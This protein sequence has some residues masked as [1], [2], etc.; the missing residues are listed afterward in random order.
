MS[1]AMS[2]T[3]PSTES[4]MLK[5]NNYVEIIEEIGNK[6]ILSIGVI[7][8]TKNIHL[9]RFSYSLAG[10]DSD[11]ENMGLFKKNIY[12]SLIL[13]YGWDSISKDETIP[14][15]VRY[16]KVLEENYHNH[17]TI[18]DQLHPVIK[19]FVRPLPSRL[20]RKREDEEYR[21]SYYLKRDDMHKAYC[22][23]DDEY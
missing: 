15:K 12:A 11:Y 19:D 8:G 22:S 21:M 16:L 13:E 9:Q 4:K 1:G 14:L 3:L 7:E 10:V 17:P 20:A 18:R 6:I 2:N 23:S 5:L